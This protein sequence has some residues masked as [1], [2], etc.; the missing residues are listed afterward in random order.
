MLIPAISLP[1]V[2]FITLL[3]PFHYAPQPCLVPSFILIALFTCPRPTI[4]ALSAF[5]PNT[6]LCED[7]T[8]S[9]TSLPRL[10]VA[11]YPPCD[12][13]GCFILLCL[14]TSALQSS[15]ESLLPL[16]EPSPRS[17]PYKETASLAGGD[18]S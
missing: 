15:W 12:F 17:Y 9:T 5:P 6:L 3:Q 18:V 10:F 13:G 7:S 1:S 4:S 14:P 11:T 16:L 8:A 2:F